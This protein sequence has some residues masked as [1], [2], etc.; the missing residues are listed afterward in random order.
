MFSTADARVYY[1]DPAIWNSV[2]VVILLILW[3]TYLIAL[4][5]YRGHPYPKPY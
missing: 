5:I 4:G 1:S 2:P 3:S